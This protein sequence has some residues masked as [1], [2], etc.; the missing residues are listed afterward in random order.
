MS[1]DGIQAIVP[2]SIEDSESWMRIISDDEDD[3][4]PPPETHKSLTSEE[5]KLVKQ[6]I[7]EGAP[8]EGHWAFSTPKKAEVP[9]INGAKNPIDAF[10]QDRLNKEGL[11]ASPSAEKETLL[12]RVYLDLTGLPPTL[13]ELDAF[14]SDQ[15]PNAWE[16]VIDDLMNRTA[17]G[18]HMARFW[19]DL[20]RYADT[21][22]LHLDNERS[23]W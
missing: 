14:I 11:T 4:M 12:R 17:Y 22:G 20:A 19:L 3:V 18:E 23:M 13:E 10:V 2:G 15:S 8:Y 16:K 7:E 6:W 5:K 1:R 21:H 9:K